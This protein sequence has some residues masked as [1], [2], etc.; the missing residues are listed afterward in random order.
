MISTIK[1]CHDC[2]FRTETCHS[3]CKRYKQEKE[4]WEK[5]KEEIRKEKDKR[6]DLFDRFRYWR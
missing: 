2:Q 3:T 6:P 5:R 1:C 4:E